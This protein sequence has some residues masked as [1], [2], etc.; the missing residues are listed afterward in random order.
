MNLANYTTG[1][2][3][4]V[5][6]D[7]LAA[8]FG[9]SRSEQDEFAVR[10]HNNAAGAHEAGWYQ[11]E[12]VPYKGSTE[13]NGIKTDSTVEVVSKLK[14]AFIKPNGTH[15][16]ANSSFLTDGAA[17]SLL[18]SE[19]KALEL[20]YKPMA[21]IRDWSFRACDPFEELLLVSL[22]T[23]GCKPFSFL[24]TCLHLFYRVPR[25]ALKR[26]LHETI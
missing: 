2:V 22:A 24:L 26:Y 15:T 20:G 12:V 16:A 5:S 8:K 3:M 10:S 19:E 11:G 25:I 23:F 4:G 21:Y 7:R 1:E 14:P 9:I 13:E 17:A 18:M 6:S